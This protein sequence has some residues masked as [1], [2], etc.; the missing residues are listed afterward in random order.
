[1]GMLMAKTIGTFTYRLIAPNKGDTP[2]N[3]IVHIGPKNWSTDKGGWVLLTPQ[4]MNEGE[5][6]YYV[7]AFK[8]DLDKVGRLAKTALRKA[9][10]RTRA[11]ARRA[12][13][14]N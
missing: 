12:R 7:A 3:A 5:I 14:P 8:A 9:N 1:M 11:A 13:D 4:L 2:F 6:D 10:D